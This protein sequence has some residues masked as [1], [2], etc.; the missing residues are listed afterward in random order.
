MAKKSLLPA[1]VIMCNIPIEEVYKRTEPLQ[2]EEFS[3]DRTILKRR[4]LYA[5]KNMPQMIFFFKKFYN[6]ITNVDAM[7]SK[8]FMED[9]AVKAISEN[10]KARMVFSRDYQYQ[11]T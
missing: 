3:C 6:N 5:E 7:K 8:W 2:R 1:N 9:L 4:L 11:G 10:L